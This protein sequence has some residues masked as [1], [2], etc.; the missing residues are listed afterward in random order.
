MQR[1]GFVALLVFANLTIRLMAQEPPAVSRTVT[2]RQ[3]ADLGGYELR[4]SL[5]HS[6]DQRRVAF[7]VETDDDRQRVVVDGKEG[8]PFEKVSKPIFSADGSRVAYVAVA[9][10]NQATLVVDGAPGKTYEWIETAKFSPNGRRLGYVVHQGKQKLVIVDDQQYGP[11]PDASEVIFSPD[12]SRFVFTVWDDKRTPV[13]AMVDGKRA[14]N[15]A[16]LVLGVDSPDLMPVAPAGESVFGPDSKRL[17][18]VEGTARRVEAGR[19]GSSVHVRAVRA[20][21]GLDVLS[22]RTP[23]RVRLQADEG[24]ERACSLPRRQTAGDVQAV[25]QPSHLQSRLEAFRLHRRRVRHLHRVERCGGNRRKEFET[26]Q[27]SSIGFSPDSTKFSFTSGY[28]VFMNGVKQETPKEFLGRAL[29]LVFSPDGR[30]IAYT[31]VDGPPETNGMAVVDGVVQ[32]KYFEQHPFRKRPRRSG[33]LMG[34]PRFSP[35]SKHVAYWACAGW[36]ADCFVVVDGTEGPHLQWVRDPVWDSP[37]S[38]RYVGA[39]GTKVIEFAETIG[40]R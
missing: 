2:E 5:V 17:A 15:S 10:K 28:G 13:G 14:G 9:G 19:P 21:H 25:G 30:R 34:R 7:V 31:T 40:G 27:I 35:D 3:L 20:R 18:Y 8:P 22:R 37:A 24:E 23:F 12:S 16:G 11:F 29:D 38:L 33:G 36:D 26:F 39:R 4:D 1:R 6:R 32:K